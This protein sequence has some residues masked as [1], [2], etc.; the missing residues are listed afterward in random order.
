M[1]RTLAML[2][3]TLAVALCAAGCAST[4]SDMP[5]NAPQ[6]WEGSPSIPGMSAPGGSGY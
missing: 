2:I 1:Q 4:E 3:V 6:P 5:W